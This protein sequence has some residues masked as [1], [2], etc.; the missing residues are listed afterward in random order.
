MIIDYLETKVSNKLFVYIEKT[1]KGQPRE[2]SGTNIQTCNVESPKGFSISN[3]PPKGWIFEVEPKDLYNSPDGKVTGVLRKGLYV[4]VNC[5]FNNRPE[6]IDFFTKINEP[7]FFSV[8]ELAW[9]GMW[10]IVAGQ[11]GTILYTLIK[12]VYL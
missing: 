9:F 7:K 10:M 6:F 3:N 12:G 4:K 1:S 2:F 8:K 5:Q 11:L